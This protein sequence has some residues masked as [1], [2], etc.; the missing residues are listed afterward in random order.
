MTPGDYEGDPYDGIMRDIVGNHVAKVKEGRAG[1]DVCV[2][3]SKLEEPISI[4]ENIAMT[5]SVSKRKAAM[6]ALLKFAKDSKLED[7]EA[8][9]LAMDAEKDDDEDKD[10]K[11]KAEDDFPEKKPDC[12]AKDKKAKDMKAKD[13]KA[14]DGES[15]MEAMDDK[16]DDDDEED[17]KEK[18]ADD[19]KA[20]DKKGMDENRCE[21]GHG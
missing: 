20:K 18:K 9:L 3:D 10:D 13:K 21:K 2:G 4:T 6:D 7:A 8:L 11:K 12:D 14:K 16:E 1:P 15:D 5:D 17:K 19:K